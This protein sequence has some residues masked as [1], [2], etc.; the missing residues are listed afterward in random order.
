MILDDRG[1]QC[2]KKACNDIPL[3]FEIQKI[4]KHQ[5]SNLVSNRT[6]SKINCFRKNP[7]SG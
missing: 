7:N 6:D 4:K 3:K 5:M 2:G 1:C